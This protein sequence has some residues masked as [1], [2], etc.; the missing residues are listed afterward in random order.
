MVGN[1][2][3]INPPPRYTQYMARVQL[4]VWGYRCERCEH[5]WVPRREEEPRVCPKCKSP[6]WNRPRKDTARATQ[7]TAKGEN[8][9]IGT[10]RGARVGNLQT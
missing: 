3:L 6:Y 1:Y 4:L 5:E 10:S 8:A 9:G 7:E 2:L